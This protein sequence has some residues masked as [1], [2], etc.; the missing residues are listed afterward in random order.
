[1]RRRRLGDIV[2]RTPG[3]AC[4]I[5]RGWQRRFVSA[6]HQARAPEMR[7]R[8][9][10]GIAVLTPGRACVIRHGLRRRFSSARQHAHALE[11]RRV[12]SVISS[13]AR[14]VA[15]GASGAAGEDDSSLRSAWKLY[16]TR[17]NARAW[18]DSG[19]KEA[20][21]GCTHATSHK[22][23]GGTDYGS[24]RGTPRSNRR[25]AMATPLPRPTG[26]YRSPAR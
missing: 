23:S 3:R 14:P 22:K 18:Q 17:K 15:L 25:V 6:R 12:D 16:S 19:V 1:M 21:E 26:T 20:P 7:R 13:Y 2:V 8:R 4:V 10:D 11:T 24:E 9:L 5:R